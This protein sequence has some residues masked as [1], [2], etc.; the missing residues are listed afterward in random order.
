MNHV[1]FFSSIMPELIR[2]LKY[3]KIL[4]KNKNKNRKFLLGMNEIWYHLKNSIKKSRDI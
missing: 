4:Y 2:I 3:F 1:K